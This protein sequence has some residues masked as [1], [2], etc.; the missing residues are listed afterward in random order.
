[1][2]KLDF[3]PITSRIKILKYLEAKKNILRCIELFPGIRYLESGLVK[4]QTHSSCKV[5]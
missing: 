5:R 2:T 3:L 1:M 4:K